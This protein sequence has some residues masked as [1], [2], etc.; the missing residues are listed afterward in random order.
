MRQKEAKR[1]QKFGTT[2]RAKAATKSR[3]FKP[4]ERQENIQAAT[5]ARIKNAKR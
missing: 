3:R 5:Y 1:L 4:F 2:I